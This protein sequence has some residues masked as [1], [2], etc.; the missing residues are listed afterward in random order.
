MGGWVNMNGI[1]TP[2]KHGCLAG[3]FFWVERREVGG[4]IRQLTD[5]PPIFLLSEEVIP[6]IPEAGERG[7]ATDE[8]SR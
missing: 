4:R 3:V 8:R 5:T 2:V 1:E 7:G 6:Q